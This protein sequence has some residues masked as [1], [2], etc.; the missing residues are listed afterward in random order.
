M[1]LPDHCQI[2]ACLHQPAGTCGCCCFVQQALFRP[3]A[4]M[5]PDY[6][7]VAEVMLFSEGFEDSKALS[8]K[9]VKLYKLASEQLSQQV[10]AAVVYAGPPCQA[11]V[12]LPHFKADAASLNYPKNKCHPGRKMWMLM[13]PQAC[14]YVIMFVRKALP[15]LHGHYI[16]PRQ[17]T[18]K[19]YRG[20]AHCNQ[21]S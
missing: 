2:T 18:E 7:L 12:D 10:C 6:A 19:L 8:R 5:I 13:P 16:G 14:W 20:P 11:V 9:M 15:Y 4:M 21:P 3:M 17:R 1:W